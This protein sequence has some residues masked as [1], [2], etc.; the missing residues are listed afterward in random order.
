M[1][2]TLYKNDIDKKRRQL[3]NIIAKAG[4]SPA[5]MKASSLVSGMMIARAAEAQN[6]GPDKSILLFAAGGAV[7]AHWRP[8]GGMQLKPMSAAYEPVKNQMNFLA[9]GQMTN[10]GHGQMFGRFNGGSEQWT[11]D[12]F[13]VNVG[14]TIGADRRVPY[15]NLGVQSGA[16]ELSKQG[17]AKVPT[18]DSPRTA[19]AQLFG[20]SGGGGGGNT[21][22]GGGGASSGPDP[23]FAFVDAHKEALDELKRKLGQHEKDRLDDHITSISAFERQLG[24]REGE[25]NNDPAPPT[26]SCSNVAMPAGGEQD[27]STGD[28]DKIAKAQIDIAMLALKC[29][30]TSS[31]S[32]AFGDD[33]HQFRIPGWNDVFHQSHHINE[34]DAG[35]PNYYITANYMSSLCAR[36]IQRAQE[37][38]IFG[39]T[40]ITQVSDMGDARKHLPENVPMFV[41]GGGIAGG[42]VSSINGKTQIDVFQA[43]AERLGVNQHSAAR[44]WSSSPANI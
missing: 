21:G 5:L 29:D 26:S 17:S 32:I 15:L 36:T 1:R 40:I 20:S 13:D 8:S 44:R 9:G 33:N 23:R 4:I 30:L 41:A 25:P 14:R 43:V 42:R 38:G 31:V 10:T 24:S 2:R 37:E 12:S 16:T 3:L 34:T 22:G 19:F 39:S 6:G 35:L 11:G 27:P 7:D 28:F 18:I